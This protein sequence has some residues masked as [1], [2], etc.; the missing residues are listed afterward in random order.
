[1]NE[2]LILVSHNDSQHR[3]CH[4]KKYACD[5]PEC[6][7][8]S[9]PVRFG[10]MRDLKRHQQMHDRSRGKRQCLYCEAELDWRSDNFQRHL[11]TS[12]NGGITAA[13]SRGKEETVKMF[14]SEH[15]GCINE[16]AGSGRTPLH[17]A[18]INQHY[19]VAWL[20]IQQGADMEM[21]TGRSKT[22]VLGYAVRQLDE[23]A[24]ALLVRGGAD[25]D[26]AAGW[27]KAEGGSLITWAARHGMGGLLKTLIEKRSNIEK[28]VL[29]ICQLPLQEQ[30]RI[31]VET[32]FQIL[33]ETSPDS[34]SRISNSTMLSLS[35]AGQLD[36][37][38]IDILIRHGAQINAKGR[39]DW[40]ALHM[41]VS[42]SP[43][44]YPS[45]NIVQELL[46]RGADCG[47][48][49]EAGE[50]PLDI[51]R[52]NRE[53]GGDVEGWLVPTI[54]DLVAKRVAV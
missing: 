4:D 10:T 16:V 54:S 48:K 25:L 22:I 17:T 19:D 2:R 1:M 8:K 38:L 45:Y 36:P 21:P 47:A 33:E 44:G 5:H 42:I 53:S 43:F 32:L 35:A 50:T 52:S 39:N 31:S 20:L 23:T 28:G 12:H 9:P 26:T 46:I 6:G 3:R 7:R 13:A 15:P 51:A 14:L 41:A 24:V 34:M 29:G 37:S 49:T 18:L 27:L 11:D 30:P 40:T